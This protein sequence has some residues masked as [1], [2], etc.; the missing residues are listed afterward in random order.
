MKKLFLFLLVPVLLSGCASP[1]TIINKSYNFNHIKRI[2]VMTFMNNE[3]EIKGIEDVFVGE[4][5]TKGFN[6]VERQTLEDVLRE[7]KLGTTGALNPD[8]TKKLGEILGVDALFFGTVTAYFPKEDENNK[9][10]YE[11]PVYKKVK[12][13]IDGTVSVVI[14]QKGVRPWK[15]THSYPSSKQ[16]YPEIGIV[17]KLI[18]AETAEIIWVGSVMTDGVN[19]IDAQ[20]NC[21]DKLVTQF[22]MDTEDQK[23]RMR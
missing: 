6:L 12:R 7:Q 19:V 15:Q 8:T 13:N 5:M 9:V 2:G 23:D 20:Q 18:D 14:E 16:E 4:L 17:A 22:W 3:M 21:I 1:R 11:E 10:I